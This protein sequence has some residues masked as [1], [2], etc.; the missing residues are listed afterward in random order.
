MGN[1]DRIMAMSQGHIRDWPCKNEH[2]TDHVRDLHE[3]RRRSSGTIG[4]FKRPVLNGL[5]ED[6]GEG[7]DSCGNVNLFLNITS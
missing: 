2:L 6:D 4:S 7:R 5:I 1:M 3:R